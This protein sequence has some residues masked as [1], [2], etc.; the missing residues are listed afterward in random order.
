MAPP[1]PF[2]PEV[3]ELPLLLPLD[4]LPLPPETS[5]LLLPLTSPLELLPEPP[6]LLLPLASSELLPPLLPAIGASSP[7]SAPDVTGG[8]AV[9]PPSPARHGATGP[10]VA[11]GSLGGAG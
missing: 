11:G 4:V 9:T 2:P 6:E 7:A 8:G 5:P 10:L 1:A 3:S